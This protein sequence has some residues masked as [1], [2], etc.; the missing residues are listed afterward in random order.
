M[1]EDEREFK[2]KLRKICDEYDIEAGEYPESP[3][4]G[5][6]V[7]DWYLETYHPDT[8]QEEITPYYKEK[9]EQEDEAEDRWFSNY[10]DEKRQELVRDGYIEKQFLIKYNKKHGTN[11]EEKRDW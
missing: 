2:E 5:R 10:T 1:D 3:Y 7:Y 8:A 11:Y 4:Q 6:A 9:A